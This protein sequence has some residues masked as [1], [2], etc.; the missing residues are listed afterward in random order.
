MLKNFLRKL[1]NPSNI[2]LFD[3]AQFGDPVALKTEWTTAKGGGSNIRTHKLIEVDS[4]RMEFQASIGAKFSMRHSLSWA[5]V[6]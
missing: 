4:T 3:P 6:A 5:L 1:S 2:P